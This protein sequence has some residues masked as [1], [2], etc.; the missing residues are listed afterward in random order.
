[1]TKLRITNLFKNVNY[2]FFYKIPSELTHC[3]FYANKAYLLNS[4]GEKKKSSKENNVKNSDLFY[5]GLKNGVNIDKRNI[6]KLEND[7][8]T[9]IKDVKSIENNKIVLYNFI[10]IILRL[11]KNLNVLLFL[12][13]KYLIGYFWSM[14]KII[15]FIEKKKLM[16]DKIILNFKYLFIYIAYSI[17]KKKDL[18]CNNN[19]INLKQFI[20]SFLSIRI[21]ENDINQINDGKLYKGEQFM[22]YLYNYKSKFKDKKKGN[23]EKSEQQKKRKGENKNMDNNNNNKMVC[24]QNY[25]NSVNNLKN[26]NCFFSIFNKNIFMNIFS[27]VKIYIIEK[28][29]FTNLD[30]KTTINFLEYSNKNMNDNMKI[31]INNI[32]LNKFL[33]SRNIFDF[34][35]FELCRLINILVNYNIKNADKLI[36]LI[37]KLLLNEQIYIKNGIKFNF[38]LLLLDEFCINDKNFSKYV[39][40]KNSIKNFNLWLHYGSKRDISSLLRDFSRMKVIN[41]SMYKILIECFLFKINYEELIKFTDLFEFRKNINTSDKN[42]NL[43][44]SKN[45]DTNISYNNDQLG[46]FK[47]YDSFK[48]TLDIIN[49]YKI[50]NYPQKKIDNYLNNE[51][52]IKIKQEILKNVIINDTLK[53]H[54]NNDFIMNMKYIEENKNNKYV[55]QNIDISDIRNYVDILIGIANVKY[56][57]EKFIYIF[58]QNI[59]KN[60]YF[61]NLK[62]MQNIILVKRNLLI[63]D[64]NNL[65]ILEKLFNFIIENH[66]NVE[67]KQLIMIFY[68]IYDYIIKKYQSKKVKYIGNVNILFHASSVLKNDNCYMDKIKDNSEEKKEDIALEL[69]NIKSELFKLLYKLSDIIFLRKEEINSMQGLVNF[70]FSLVNSINV[71]SIE[72]YNFFYKKFWCLLN[73]EGKQNIKVQTIVQIFLLHYKNNMIHKK[74][75]LYL[76]DILNNPLVIDVNNLCTINFI[77]YH[78]NIIDKSFFNFNLNI[79]FKEIKK[80]EQQKAAVVK[81]IEYD[82][83]NKEKKNENDKKIMLYEYRI[84]NNNEISYTDEY[85]LNEGRI[86]SGF[87]ESISYNTLEENYD[88]YDN[89]NNFI[90]TNNNLEK[91]IYN[92]IIKCIWSL[93]LSNFFLESSRIIFLKICLMLKKI[94]K[95]KINL[96][97]EEY[98]II[99][100]IMLS[101]NLYYKKNKIKNNLNIPI[102]FYV[103][104]SVIKKA[105][106]S[107]INS[108][109]K[110]NISSFQYKISNYLNKKG[111]IYKSEYSLKYGIIVDF[112]LFKNKRPFLLLEIDGIYHYN[113]SNEYNYELKYNNIFLLKNG[114]TVFR[115]NL[116]Q[117]LYHLKFI[118]IPWFFFLQSESLKKLL[119]ILK[120]NKL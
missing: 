97:D 54:K 39:L 12:K 74:L 82:I 115:N 86:I 21:N 50:N 85:H 20:F 93:V 67:M 15:N 108:Q 29:K 3:K 31:L 73:Q 68:S 19:I 52:K 23:E 101:L 116:L 18:Q 69:H 112:L 106:R 75:F 33:S 89:F 49:K 77:S 118:S 40:K 120:E 63:L 105:I 51:D 98:N 9:I 110:V 70:Y 87:N 26:Q 58:V 17:I 48:L 57:Y 8:I 41:N 114:R 78:F 35:T 79:L 2:I 81:N 102:T 80:E 10:D 83:N 64:Y 94:F 11:K 99:Y 111:I 103:P 104:Y 61:F 66:K 109:K 38:N 53:C 88:F 60:S 91:E 1:M 25:N 32:L 65:Y 13:E 119:D 84:S 14:C 16:D 95:N 113:I 47:K 22:N 30:I 28:L 44:K 46:N 56:F 4:S 100:Q 107:N 92:K 34:S 36:S 24:N 62:N 42:Y 43:S 96:S 7:I 76:L 5:E 72:K 55:D 59:V 71:L 37:I 6:E 117:V 27:S 90:D 45:S